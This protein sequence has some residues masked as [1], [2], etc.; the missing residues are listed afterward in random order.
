MAIDSLKHW[1]EMH[2]M[3]LMDQNRLDVCTHCQMG[4]T[5]MIL[6][7]RK[8]WKCCSPITS[9]AIIHTVRA[10][11]FAWEA[12]FC[13]SD[14]KN[15]LKPVRP[16]TMR[17][18]TSRRMPFNVTCVAMA[19][20]GFALC[21]VDEAVQSV[22]PNCLMWWTP[23]AALDASYSPTSISGIV[24]LNCQARTIYR[25]FRCP[26]MFQNSAAYFAFL[27]LTWHELTRTCLMLVSSS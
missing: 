24:E 11:S 16:I 2:V 12:I 6:H 20:L 5:S 7:L 4:G 1:Y 26:T 13:T 23:W 3:N 21:Y 14:P 27:I 8:L 15:C 17:N 10:I 19:T 9:P 22:D 18:C 25:N